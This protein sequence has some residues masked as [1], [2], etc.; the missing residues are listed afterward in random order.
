MQRLG[1]SSFCIETLSST[2]VLFSEPS[3]AAFDLVYLLSTW[4]CS[5]YTHFGL[6]L[7]EG[8]VH[9]II[10]PPRSMTSGVVT[11]AIDALTSVNCL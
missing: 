9:Q 11:P 7:L 6:R 3:Y 8:E 10:M 2:V 5:H 1:V 4:L